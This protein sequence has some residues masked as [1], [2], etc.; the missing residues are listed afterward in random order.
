MESIKNL[1]SN[2]G[3]ESNEGKFDQNTLDQDMYDIVNKICNIFVYGI[4]QKIHGLKYSI[5]GDI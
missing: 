4:V 5:K 3:Q 2:E 1:M